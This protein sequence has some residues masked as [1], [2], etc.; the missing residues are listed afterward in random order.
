MDRTIH[1]GMDR[2]LKEGF[3]LKTFLHLHPFVASNIKYQVLLCCCCSAAAPGA[4]APAAAAPAAHARAPQ[5][6]AGTCIPSGPDLNA[7]GQFEKLYKCEEAWITN[8]ADSF[9]F[10]L[11]QLS[12]FHGNDAA[13]PGPLQ[14]PSFFSAREARSRGSK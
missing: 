5:D 6:C 10:S 14:E 7:F 8:G 1:P 11:K 13:R 2:D 9:R 3:M 12:E 4:A